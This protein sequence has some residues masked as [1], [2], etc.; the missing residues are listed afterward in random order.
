MCQDNAYT[1]QRFIKEE[2][3]FPRLRHVPHSLLRKAL[4]GLKQ[5]ARAWYLKLKETLLSSGYK[6]ATAD[7]SLYLRGQGNDMVVLLVYVDD[8]LLMGNTVYS[9]LSASR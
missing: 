8:I 9:R 5:A 1:G 4:Y 2:Q 3:G 6:V 7:P